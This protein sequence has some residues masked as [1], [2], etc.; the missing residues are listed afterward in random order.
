MQNE[1]LTAATVL[2]GLGTR[3]IGQRLLVYPAVSSTMDIAR[4]QARRQAPE[5]TAVVAE[6]QTAGRGR[7]KRV[8]Q[9][10]EGNIAVSVVLYPP[11]E[12]LPSLIMLTSLAVLHG[13]RTATGLAC[14]LKWPNDVLIG[15]KK[16]SGILIE[17]QAKTGRLDYAIPG[18][19]I[20]VNM[21]L[22]DYPELQST[23][24]SLTDETGKPVSR[25]A[26]L[27]HLFTEL[28][29]LYLDMLAGKPLFPEWRDNLATLGRRVNVTSGDS[30]IEGTAESVMEDGCL[31][32]RCPDGTLEK[33]TIGDVSLR[34]Q[35]ES[36]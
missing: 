6:R 12:C 26:V 24:T 15:G 32:L 17:T 35:K 8:W 7:L 31:L 23:A 2:H 14:Q 5:G 3:F 30:S 13:I 10:P 28:E 36:R 20:N 34:D 1:P 19:G 16:V 27:R 4:E 22:A 25:I 21:R 33:I 29:R 9:T 18:I 11:R